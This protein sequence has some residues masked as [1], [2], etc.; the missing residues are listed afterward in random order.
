MKTA[1][2]LAACWG[3]MYVLTAIGLGGIDYREQPGSYWDGLT[4]AR[5]QKW[6]PAKMASGAS[7]LQ[8]I[9]KHLRVKESQYAGPL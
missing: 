2:Y 6:Y 1:L 4:T 3:A 5:F 7:S 9:T 8:S